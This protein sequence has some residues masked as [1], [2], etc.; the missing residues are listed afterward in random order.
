MET[1]EAI[2][3]RRSVRSFE[4]TPVPRET[5]ERIVDA[6]RL[7]PTGVNV[8]PWH[9]VAVTAGE[10]R[11]ALA[12]LATRGGFIADAPLCVAVFCAETNYWLEDGCAATANIILA[13]T[14]HGLGSCW[15]AGEKKP[16]A[17]DVARLL[18]AP[19][20]LR[21][22]A[23]VAIGRAK[24]AAAPVPKKPLSEVLHWERF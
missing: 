13:A 5:V 12:G 1:M 15:V 23:L 11:R 6:G 7:A 16:Y 20:G 4:A 10:T 9:F 2:A 19:A 3:A 24:G 21:L 18:G 14:A 22:V 17:R 8:Q